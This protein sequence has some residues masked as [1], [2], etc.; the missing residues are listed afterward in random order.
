MDS[1]LTVQDNELIL[2]GT[3]ET[4]KMI[5]THWN[6]LKKHVHVTTDDTNE[7]IN[8]LERKLNIQ[9]KQADEYL[10]SEIIKYKYKINELQE[11]KEREL[12][13]CKK[14]YETYIEKLNELLVIKRTMEPERKD[15]VHIG[16][17]YEDE[18]YNTLSKYYNSGYEIINDTTKFC[19]DITI[20]SKE[21]GI[22]V[23][24]E[25]KNYSNV[26]PQ[27][28]RNKFINDVCN[29]DNQF[30]AGIFISKSIGLS[31]TGYVEWHQNKPCF[32]ITDNNI[33]FL[34]SSI[35]FLFSILR[36]NSIVSDDTLDLKRK[37]KEYV[38]ILNTHRKILDKMGKT[39]KTLTREYTD[40]C[41]LLVEI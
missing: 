4:L 24:I 7:Y 21:T 29:K 26:I 13:S 15:L 36:K 18:I 8:T 41:D 27:K 34:I 5:Y 6:N 12:E 2:V 3:N 33:P 19:G 20:I 16:Q 40:M 30:S 22:R 38:R 39:I 10:D 32:Y 28:E 31:N 11:S 35:N 17:N 9:R 23:C 25:A 37:I 14:H 1:Y